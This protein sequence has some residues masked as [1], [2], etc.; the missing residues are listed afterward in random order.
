M[1][2]KFNLLGVIA[3]IAIAAF[4]FA[5]CDGLLDTPTEGCGC[6]D[7]CNDKCTGDCCSNCKKGNDQGKEKGNDKEPDNNDADNITITVTGN[8]SAY[9]GKRAAMLVYTGSDPVAWAS[10][11]DVAP[12][13]SSLTF[14]ILDYVTDES[15]KTAGTYN[16]LL[17]FREGTDKASD[18]SY[19][20]MSQSITTGT[21]TI[22][23]STIPP[24]AAGLPAELIG[25][26]FPTEDVG[27]FSP[28]TALVLSPD[29]T[30]F[31]DSVD[32][33][34]TV[35]GNKLILTFDGYEYDY[36]YS[37]E[38]SILTLT[39]NGKTG[40]YS[41]DFTSNAIWPSNDVWASF[42]L[43]GFTQPA[44]SSVYYAGVDITWY[45]FLK[46]DL[47]VV[48]V[49]GSD[50]FEDLRDQ[51]DALDIDYNVDYEMYDIYLTANYNNLTIYYSMGSITITAEKP[52]ALYNNS[53]I[54][55][56]GSDY[57]VIIFGWDDARFFNGSVEFAEF[58][59]E[60]LYSDGSIGI[61][62]YLGGDTYVYFDFSFTLEG[63]TLT[64][65]DLT[66][67]GAL[68]LSSFNGVYTKAGG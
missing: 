52:I 55:D 11:V 44:G 49:A 68:E 41:Q 1:K 39:A 40:T 36:V 32:C 48:L 14:T 51:L 28:D 24:L 18:V 42:G 10:F 20:K 2:N 33:T 67:D 3:L 16:V 30:G 7:E 34:W 60:Y 9:N 31:M 12:G 65:S 17:W 53:W 15:F 6:C 59:I 38:D 23:F 64:I 47:Y 61:C 50:A 27:D 56:G 37:I 25:A 8:F 4:S 13:A 21:N 29:G 63:D 26:W 62:Y 58:D 35:N 46:D 54:K 19:F 57:K 45:H 66:D 5:A 43:P 22:Q